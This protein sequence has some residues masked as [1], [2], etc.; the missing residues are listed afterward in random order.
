[1]NGRPREYRNVGADDGPRGIA[2]ALPCPLVVHEEE[3]EFF[4]A[5]G[6]AQTAPED[7]LLDDRPWLALAVQKEL[8]RVEHVVAEELIDIAVKFAGAGLQNR[9]DVAA[10]ISSLAR[11]VE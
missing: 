8:V 3:T 6:S 7:I 11:V 1:M 10:A 4:A 2:A 9:V 5:D